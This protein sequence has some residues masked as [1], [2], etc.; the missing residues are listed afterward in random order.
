MGLLKEGVQVAVI[1]MGAVF[2][3][4]VLMVFLMNSLYRTIKPWEDMLE[5][6]AEPARKKPAA[7]GDSAQLAAAV[8]AAAAVHLERGGK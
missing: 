7:G 1:G 2:S 6:P 8:A 5:A 4:L 3:F